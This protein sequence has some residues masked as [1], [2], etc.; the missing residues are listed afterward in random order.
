MRF[1]RIYV[2]AVFALCAVLSACNGGKA[3]GSDKKEDG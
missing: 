1:A 2:P 3:A